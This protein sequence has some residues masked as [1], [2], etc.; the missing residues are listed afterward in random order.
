ML[1]QAGSTLLVP[2][3]GHTGNDVAESIAH[4]AVMSLTPERPPQRRVVVKAGSKGESVA[5][6]AR[7]YRVSASDVATW[8]KV[9]VKA[10][11][12]PG[13]QIVLMLPP[14]AAARASSVKRKPAAKRAAR[15]A[16]GKRS[17]RPASR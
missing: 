16:A 7:R 6:V 2:R 3:N 10:R 8:N 11:F 12:K 4:N 9:G 17:T 1:V 5:A 15:P 14:K 13:Q